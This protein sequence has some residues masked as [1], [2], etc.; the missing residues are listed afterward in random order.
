VCSSD[1]DRKLTDVFAVESE[2]ATKI[3]DTLQ[4]KLT[5]S[6]QKRITM[7]PTDDSDAHQ[8]YLRGRY[9]WG[10]QTGADL[11]KAIDYFNQAIAKDPHYA[12]AYAGLSD[13]YQV[14]FFWTPNPA[15]S[16]RADYLQKARVT[17]EK[18]LKIDDTLGEAHASLGSTLFLSEF[19]LTGAKREFERA[20]QLNP[21]YA[22]AH[23]WFGDTVL[24]AQGEIDRAIAEAKRAV[25]LD[26]FSSFINANLGY[27]YMMARRYPEAIAQ[28]RKTI[29]LNPDYYLSHQNLAQAL[30]LSGHLDEA[31][32]EYEKPHGPSHEPYVLAFRAHIYGIKGD[33]AKALQLLNEMKQLAQQRDVWSA[34]FALAYLGL[35]DK[36]EAINWLERSYQAKEYEM[37]AL[38]KLHPMLD[39]LR[40]DPRFE[41]LVTSLAL[42]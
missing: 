33:R 6:E 42:K 7:R 25:E 24:L 36:D 3:A 31:I 34:G 35:G 23:L 20:L 1:L 39:P 41:R 21:N 29:E 14:L 13:C 12:A 2:I 18:A 38:L 19:N 17:A 10:K 22:T 5:T 11:E 40:G 9:F 27:T 30:E 37:M 15:S 26:P 8:L 32:V 16:E 4:A 28:D